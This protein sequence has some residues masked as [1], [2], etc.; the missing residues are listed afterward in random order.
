MLKDRI[1]SATK[2]FMERMPKAK[3][4][5]YGQ[6]FTT[7]DSANFMASLFSFKPNREMLR[8]LDAGAGSG[9]LCTS[10]VE[11]LRSCG[12]K[13]GIELTCYENDPSILPLLKDALALLESNCQVKCKLETANY[14]TSQN[15]ES[16]ETANKFD[17]VIG[18]PPYRK[19]NK[20]AQEAK[21]MASVCY[22]APNLYFLFMAMGIHNLAKN[23]ELV[24]I[25]PRSW[26]SGAYFE[27]FR[28]YLLSNCVIE[29]IHLFGSR[30]EVFKGDPVLQE[31][32]IIKVKKASNAPRNITISFSESSDFYD[33]ETNKIKYSTI[34]GKNDYIY[35]ATNSEEESVLDR[36]EK[37]DFT[38]EGD[39]LRM[40]TGLVVDFRT[41]EELRN[42]DGLDTYPL[43][44]SQHIKDGGIVWPIGK[45]NEYICTKRKALLQDNANYLFVKRFTAKEE[46]RRLQCGMY[47]LKDHPK[48]Q[49]IST[50][51]K[52]NFIR[53]DTVDETYGLYA[54]FN[55]TIYDKYYRILNGSTQVNSTEINKMPVPSKHIIS[56]IGKEL[57]NMNLTEANCDK[58]V[59]KWIS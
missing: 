51:N 45:E 59:N 31:T 52:I 30:N 35:L 14:L 32:M 54:L 36:L 27:R 55:S 5:E 57:Q 18:N 1:I 38:L 39:G 13:G 46:R 34:V 28:K 6:F 56:C 43:L 2:A 19:I 48:Y 15:F 23:G 22:G 11:R 3:R 24:Y 53:C 49:Y 20:S 12:F 17:L 9:I 37:L 16:D 25:I 21:C 44:Y 7:L 41:R 8:I 50:Q 10:L 33:T 29:H 42:H 40:K 58:V 26:T 47:F 4:K